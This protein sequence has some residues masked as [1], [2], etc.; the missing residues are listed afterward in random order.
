MTRPGLVY[1]L[2]GGTSS[3]QYGIIDWPAPMRYG[4]TF[5][6][7]AARTIHNAHAVGTLRSSAKVARV[8]GKPEDGARVRRLGRRP[9]PRTSTPSWST[10]TASTPTA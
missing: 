3:Y 7:N 1:N 8:L 2:L 6:N 5:T 4:Y 9:R 10:P